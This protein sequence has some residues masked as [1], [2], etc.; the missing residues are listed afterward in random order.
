MSSQQ[1]EQS[2]QSEQGS[3]ARS[4]SAEEV[5]RTTPSKA[6][7][8]PS[9]DVVLL[10]AVGLAM[11]L[12]GG[13]MMF[14]GFGPTFT[15]DARVTD[16]QITQGKGGQHQVEGVDGAGGGFTTGVPAELSSEVTT[17]DIVVVHRAV[18]TGR[19]VGIDGPGWR[20]APGAMTAV[21]GIAVAFGLVAFG[22][23]VVLW[24]RRLRAADDDTSGATSRLYLPLLAALV[25]VLLAATV[26]IMSERSVAHAGAG[27]GPVPAVLSR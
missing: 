10:F 16:T 9:S 21:F 3:Q 12:W 1:S 20:Y 13:I 11:V 23:F 7:R 27:S 2:P 22:F 25:V 17:G 8:V 26:W 15:R 19:V 5:A 24:R 4:V 6:T 18:L 14:D